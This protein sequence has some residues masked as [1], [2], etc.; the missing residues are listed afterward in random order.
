MLVSAIQQR[1][2]VIAIH[3]YPPSWASLRPSNPSR[4]S[5]STGL[6]CLLNVATSQQ[7][8][9][10]HMIVYRC[11]CSSLHSSRSLFPT[12]STSLFSISA[13]PFLP[14][15]QFH[16]YCFF[17]FHMYALIYNICFSLSDL[18]RSIQQALSS[19]TSLELTQICSFLCWVIVHC[20]YVP[21]LLCLFICRWTPRLHPC[22]GY[23]K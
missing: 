5:Q 21:H 22:P 17:R 13:S 16:Q 2:S 10:S 15:K 12:E 19:S 6:G 11:R 14:W 3:I 20:I 9:I 23:C 18:L 1:K 7:L 8:S 4:L